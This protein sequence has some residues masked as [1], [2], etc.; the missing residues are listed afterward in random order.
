MAVASS[1]GRDTLLRPMGFAI[2]CLPTARSPTLSTAT[3]WNVWLAIRSSAP[4]PLACSRLRS[5]TVMSTI[6]AILLSALSVLST[7]IQLV[8]LAPRLQPNAKPPTQSQ[9][10]A[11]L[12]SAIL[13]TSSTESVMIPIACLLMEIPASSAGPISFSTTTS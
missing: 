7:I 10:H 5:L 1:V 11:H 12:V 13:S 6:P 4:D 3:A 2:F 9:G 8:T